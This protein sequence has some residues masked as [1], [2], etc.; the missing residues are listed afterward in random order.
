MVV[1]ANSGYNIDY[2]DWHLLNDQFQLQIQ[3]NRIVKDL[4]VSKYFLF[5]GSVYW[6]VSDPDPGISVRR[7]FGTSHS[8]RSNWKIRNRCL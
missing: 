2:I 4:V 6:I 1:L 3:F 7:Y 8:Y 5:S